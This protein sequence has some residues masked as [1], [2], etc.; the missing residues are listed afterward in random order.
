MAYEDAN[1]QDGTAQYAAHEQG[2]SPKGKPELR[3]LAYAAGAVSLVGFLL[4]FYM[5]VWVEKLSGREVFA[6]T[7]FK[8]RVQ[9]VAQ[10]AK[11]APPHRGR[12][13]SP[14]LQVQ[15]LYSA[16]KIGPYRLTSAQ[17]P[18]RCSL[19][20]ETSVYNAQELGDELLTYHVRMADAS[21]NTVWE[22]EERLPQEGSGGGG[23]EPSSQT[24]TVKV[25]SVPQ[26]GEYSFWPRITGPGV[27]VH[28]A[29]LSMRRNVRTGSQVVALVGCVMFLLGLLVSISASKAY[30]IS[31]GKPVDEGMTGMGGIRD[32]SLRPMASQ[33]EQEGPEAEAAGGWG[34]QRDRR[35]R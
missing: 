12:Y 31:R 14:K 23:G 20:M 13:A 33:P 26:D 27:V 1:R 21:G 34:Q 28:R 18:F 17:N 3:T 8:A 15:T 2:H 29:K 9:R 6:K 10:K 11:P 5:L 24:F 16:D 25:F 4:L 32:T 19:H 7:F 30:D 22:A 35:K